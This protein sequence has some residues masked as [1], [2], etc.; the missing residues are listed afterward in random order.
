M[1]VA[2]CEGLVGLGLVD[3]VALQKEA[4]WVQLQAEVA[5][6]KAVHE[7]AENEGKHANEGK[8]ENEGKHGK[9]ISFQLPALIFLV[10][11]FLAAVS[12]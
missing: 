3:E 2:S 8:H 4:S 7:S 10:S 12:W 1:Q 11:V 6:E 5:R 9:T